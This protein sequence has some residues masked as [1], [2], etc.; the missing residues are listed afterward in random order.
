M[1]ATATLI[2]TAE[3][4]VNVASSAEAV[5]GPNGTFAVATLPT[6]SSASV[7]T[8]GYGAQA[9]I[10]A[11][12]SSIDSVAVTVHWYTTFTSGQTVTAQ[13]V[14]GG[15]PFGTAQTLTPSTDSGNSETV[16]FTGVTWA[17]LANLGVL[18]SV[19]T[20]APRTVRLDAQTVVVN[21]TDN[22]KVA[23]D[24]A[25]AVDAES[26]AAI[27]MAVFGTRRPVWS[28]TEARPPTSG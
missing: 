10:G 5:G 7:T 6:G 13:L 4:N 14:S 8:S 1:A 11:P 17:Q 9:A 21:Y 23:T 24:S 16:T 27:A 3:T 25:A 20:T 12:P 18:W 19:S 26:V 22:A 28:H 2:S 15:T